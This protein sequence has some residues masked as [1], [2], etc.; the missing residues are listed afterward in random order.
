MTC[1]QRVLEVIVLCGSSHAQEAPKRGTTKIATCMQMLP[2]K[3]GRDV[4][5]HVKTHCS[6][7]KQLWEHAR[8]CKTTFKQKHHHHITCFDQGAQDAGKFCATTACHAKQ[9]EQSLP[10]TCP[11]KGCNKLHSVSVVLEIH[12]AIS[13]G[14]SRTFLYIIHRAWKKTQQ[15]E[16]ICS[17]DQCVGTSTER[18]EAET[19]V[20]SF[21]AGA[22][23]MSFLA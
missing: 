6:F 3:E 2:A 14:R 16:E 15:K 13:T 10:T 12:C 7:S 20:R 22:M 18:T 17:M 21:Q 19:K 1:L 23:Q 9:A 4:K 5:Q 11:M 8:L